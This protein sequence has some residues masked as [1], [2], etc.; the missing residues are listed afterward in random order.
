MHLRI[1]RFSALSLA[2]ARLRR[3]FSVGFAKVELET[4]EKSAFV[5]FLLSLLAVR[6]SAYRSSQHRR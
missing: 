2:V 6:V 3:P 4:A 5:D 1:W